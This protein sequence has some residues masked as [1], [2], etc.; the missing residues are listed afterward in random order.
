MPSKLKI[1]AL[2]LLLATLPIDA[3][4]PSRTEVV[5]AIASAAHVHVEAGQGNHTKLQ[6]LTVLFIVNYAF[7][8]LLIFELNFVSYQAYH[9][10]STRHTS[11]SR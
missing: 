6:L 1:L 11:F 7:L 5:A 10:R 4:A 8:R 3:A 9:F 2:L